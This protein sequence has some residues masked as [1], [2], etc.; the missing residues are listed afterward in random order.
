MGSMGPEMAESV[1]RANGRSSI[2]LCGEMIGFRLCY[3][4]FASNSVS[5]SGVVSR[6]RTAD[7]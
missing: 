1:G 6:M 4:N 2:I 7:F 3:V 5:V